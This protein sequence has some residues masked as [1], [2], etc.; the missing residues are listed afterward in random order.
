MT[1]VT[2][3]TSIGLI[4]A[5]RV[6]QTLA[7]AFIRAGFNLAAVW[8]PS[9]QAVESFRAIVPKLKTVGAPEDVAEA[10]ETILLAVPDDSIAKV[11]ARLSA[12]G[13]NW[14][15]KTVAHFSGRCGADVLAPLH[16]L[17]A[18]VIAFHPA[19]AFAGD[20]V[21]DVE[22]LANIRFAI[23]AL[24]AQA[25]KRGAALAQAIGTR[26]FII[27]NEY[28]TVYHA[29]LTHASNHLVTLVVQ[30]SRL[31]AN[32]G[33][34][35]TSDILRPALEAALSNAL[36]KGAAGATGPVVR[37]DEGTV[38]EHVLALSQQATDVLSTYTALTRAG[39][40]IAEKDGRVTAEQARK[41]EA[42]LDVGPS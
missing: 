23:S 35:N 24:T 29:A 2:E 15:S 18:C 10:A 5:G 42:A 19:M 38:H 30:A 7:L 21:S 8:D 20:V 12:G 28:R 36:A 6:G 40:A 41:L 4:G 33:I 27:A 32:I 31:L 26:P 17:G 37:G 34:D 3:S 1:S 22:C 14:H 25:E 11:T 9:P 13:T 16:N 39:I